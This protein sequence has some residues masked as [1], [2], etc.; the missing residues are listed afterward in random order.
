MYK[1]G[2]HWPQEGTQLLASP[3]WGIGGG[4]EESSE[5]SFIC[6]FKPKSLKMITQ[7]PWEGL[8]NVSEPARE[9]HSV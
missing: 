6:R 2:L 4:G 9:V 8:G 7:D 3:E 5:V 1:V